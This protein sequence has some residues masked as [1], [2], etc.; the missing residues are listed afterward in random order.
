MEPSVL[1]QE[2]FLLLCEELAA[3]RDFGTL[4]NCSLVSRRFA[5]IA[6]EQIY[7]IQ[8]YSPVSTGE[9]IYKSEWLQLWKSI[10]LSSIK[11]TAFPYCVYVRALSLGNLEEFLQDISRDIHARNI[12]FGGA[13][14]QFF[15]QKTSEY[16]KG[17]LPPMDIQATII[18]CAD[19]ITQYIKRLADDTGTAVSL[20]HLEGTYIPHHI[21]PT[22]IA[23]LETLTSLR[24][25]DGSVLGVEAASAISK[26]CPQFV[27]LTCYYCML[28]ILVFNNFLS[29]IT[30]E[31]ISGDQSSTADEDLAAFLQALRPNSLRSFEVISQN[32]IGEHALTSL[33][34]H[35]AS[36]RRLVLRN[37]TPQAMK[38]LNSFPNCT[39][40]DTLLIE[41]DLYNLVDPADYP[42]ETLE[43]VS[44]WICKCKSL[45]DLSFSHFTGSDPVVRNILNSPN[46]R[47]ASLSII[48]IRLTEAE[49]TATWTALGLQDHLESLT[50]GIH[51]VG[52]GNI[53]EAR[54]P[55]IDSICRLKN[56]ASLNLMQVHLTQDT[57]ERIATSLPN[58]SEFSFSGDLLHNSV[59]IPLS[60]VPKL[61]LL[62]ISSLSSFSFQGLYKFVSRLISRGRT[63][64]KIDILNQ[65][66]ECKLTT[67]ESDLLQKH[68][69]KH[70][71]G[72][73]EIAY[74]MDPDELHETDLS[75]ASD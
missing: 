74:F 27:D 48:S 54:L 1:P 9:A 66:G 70:L 59:L 12:F 60:A 23:R 33:D 63:G 41:N 32:S 15:L 18:K 21:L 45:R 71:K 65:L 24:I 16:T 28:S 50:L 8:E 57:V 69:I 34:C 53:A 7:S 36:L 67:S 3:R 42:D 58:L 72:R 30:L 75:D 10:I 64:I 52:Y 61:K 31:V 17:H 55:L 43:E 26:C 37:L 19:S 6:L 44:A 47:L 35:A 38:A 4:F 2:I 11:E 46:I 25:R 40:L 62:C 22:W 5:S 20:A 14:R 51:E 68:F 13:M 39:T 73:L 56:L 29:S 49:D